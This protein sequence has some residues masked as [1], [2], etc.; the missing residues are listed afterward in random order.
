MLAHKR[1]PRIHPW[2]LAALA[3]P[4]WAQNL[5]VAP[6]PSTSPPQT[7]L[8]GRSGRLGEEGG[9]GGGGGGGLRHRWEEGELWI[10]AGRAE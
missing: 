6:P 9:E 5:A 7:T 1:C 4:P 3:S 8:I 2:K 10:Q